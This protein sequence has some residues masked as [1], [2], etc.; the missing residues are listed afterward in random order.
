MLDE[1]DKMTRL[2]GTNGIRGIVNK[3][4]NAELA[5][6]IGSAW[7]TY[8]K[9]KIDRPTIAIGTDVRLSSDMLKS[10]VIS[11][12]LSTG[13]NVTDLGVVPT[14][15]LQYAVR[16]RDFD[17]GV[18]IT[19]SHNPPQ[20]NGI[21]GS[22]DDGIEFSKDIE[23]EIEKIYFQ[24]S[25][26]L[27]SWRNVGKLKKW[28]ESVDLYIKGILSNVDVNL[29]KSKK[30]HVVLDCGNGAGC[31][32]T[33]RILNLLGC[34][35]TLLNCN[36][37]GTFPGRDPEPI[38]ENLSELI[39]K[40]PSVNADI[41][42]AQDGDADRAIFVDEKGNYLWGD[43]TLALVAKYI[44][45][46]NQGGICVSPVTSS[47]CLEEVVLANGGKLISTRVGSPIVASNMKKNMAIF[48][49][50]ENGGLI[51]PEM[52][53][54]RDSAMSI[55]T[56]LEIIAVEKKP[57]TE[58]IDELPAYENFKIKT[59][60]PDEKKESILEK[61]I[62]ITRQDDKVVKIDDTDGIKLYYNF[63]W[64]IIRPSGTEPVFRIFSESKNKA[65]AEYLA[66]KYKKLTEALILG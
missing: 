2:F 45:N 53:Y 50:E 42:V 63:G 52:Q 3:G 46:K 14:P 48:G 7:G 21:K 51:F 10:A 9:K 19:A 1:N 31:M 4:M 38:P 13:C 40:V 37:N 15:C 26:K 16:K 28:D 27:E 23:E 33:P 29:I 43:K 55:A 36:A 54:S 35:T 44:T 20:F 18:I 61:I 32:V 24:K 6:G 60:C 17:S 47:S 8:F 59:S 56:M 41:G 30:L 58:L 11:G 64:V 39:R 25:F 12:L 5:L 62:T 49:G 65:K 22:S 57:L 34:K 66:L